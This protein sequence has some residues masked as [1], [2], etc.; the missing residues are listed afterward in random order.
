MKSK[1]VFI[2]SLVLLL[3]IPSGNVFAY[4]I[5]ARVFNAYISP[6]SP[7]EEEDA[8]VPYA[9]VEVL[10]NSTG[11]SYS[12][13][14]TA[15]ADDEGYVVIENVPDA[16]VLIK[17]SA[18]DCIDTYEYEWFI[19]Y[20]D[21]N[22]WNEDQTDVLYEIRGLTRNTSMATLG[23]SAYYEDESMGCGEAWYGGTSHD[24]LYISCDEYGD[25]CFTT[26]RDPGYDGVQNG[27]GT[28]PVVSAIMTFNVA[29]QSMTTSVR[30]SQT[31]VGNYSIPYICQ[32]CAI[33]FP[34]ESSASTPNWCTE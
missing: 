10:Q 24:S 6:L 4:T 22:I 18:D 3:S 27:E 14:L 9:E 30:Y 33:L 5:N 21:I 16:V 11:A 8:Y 13:P 15:T 2:L 20:E 17:A 31:A 29:A 28:N 32:N 1:S 25:D 34:V 7:R 19:D 12:P 26:D 23:W